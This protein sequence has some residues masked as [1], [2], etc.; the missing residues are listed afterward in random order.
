MNGYRHDKEV[1]G[2]RK[3]RLPTKLP[4]R[5]RISLHIDDEDSVV[6]NAGQ[7]GFKAMRVFEPD[8]DWAQKILAEARR[9]RDI[10]N[11]EN[12]TEGGV[13]P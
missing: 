5:Y 9:I 4:N 2:E 10:E 7:Y 6:R 3:Q 12:A 13:R 11:R 8:D 1:Q